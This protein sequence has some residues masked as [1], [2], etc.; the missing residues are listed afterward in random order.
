MKKLIWVFLLLLLSSR[1]FAGNTYT[2]QSKLYL[3]D[4]LLGA[5]VVQ[6]GDNEKAGVS[7]SGTYDFEVILAAEDSG[8]VNITSNISL[9]DKVYQ[10]SITIEP[11]NEGSVQVGDFKWSL[12][13]HK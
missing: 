6:L 3:E 2:I 13:V 5:P 9:R 12:F 7:V 4:Q 10:P 8:V 1:V 11:G